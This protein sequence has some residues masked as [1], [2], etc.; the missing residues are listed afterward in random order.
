MPDVKGPVIVHSDA[1][2]LRMLDLREQGLSKAKIAA[3]IGVTKN[4]IVGAL[5]RISEDMLTHDLTPERNGE[6]PDGWWR[7]GLQK[8]GGT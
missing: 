4:V 7:A 2:L 8:Q 3:R 1:T 6:M 5:Y